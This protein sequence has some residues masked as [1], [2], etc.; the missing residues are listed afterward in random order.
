M[1]LDALRQV[2]AICPGNRHALGPVDSCPHL[3]SHFRHGG[4]TQLLCADVRE[5]GDVRRRCGNFLRRASDGRDCQA[6]RDQRCSHRARLLQEV[7]QN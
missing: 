4:E 1:R 5:D 3:D 7:F 6:E 2:L